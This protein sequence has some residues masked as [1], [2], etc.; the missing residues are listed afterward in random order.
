MMLNSKEFVRE[1]QLRH[2]SAWINP[3]TTT[4]SAALAA[5]SLTLTDVDDAAARLERFAPF[6]KKAFP[7]TADHCGLIESPL[8]E[9][10]KMRAWLAENENA[11][12]A[13]KLF[14]KRDSDLPV[15]GSVK[16][17]GG[18]Y[19]VLK[20]T[21]ELAL[22]NHLIKPNEDYSVFASRA[23]RSFFSRYELHVGSTGNLGL[24]IGIMG[25]A[26]GYRVTVHMSAD[27]RQ[28]KKDLLR[29]KGVTVSEYGAD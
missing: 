6:I 27:A 2:E 22:A 13:G 7:E 21:E 3:D 11:Q 23:F 28:W 15:A 25:A 8:T 12:L 4:A 1:L 18:C 24:S 14:L 29:E 5:C 17:R 10:E 19:A 9:I 26:L 20:H 16:A